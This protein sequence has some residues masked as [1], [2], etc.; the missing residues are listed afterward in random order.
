MSRGVLEPGA[1]DSTAVPEYRKPIGAGLPAPRSLAWNGFWTVAMSSSG[2]LVAV[3]VPPFL[4]RTLTHDEYGAWALALQFASYVLVLGFGLQNAVG[5]FVA[6]AHGPG[7]PAARS[8]VVV[9]A[10]HMACVAA[11]AGVVLVGAACFALPHFLT[12]M[13]EALVGDFRAALLLC[14]A[15]AALALIGMPFTGVFLGE[16]RAHVPAFIV[17]SGRVAQCALLVGAALGFGT[18]ESLAV[19]Y[20]I[21]Q[22]LITGGQ[23]VA[24]GAGGGV[25]LLRRRA[26]AAHYRELWS[27]C[28]PFVLWNSLAALSF[29][30]DLLI[31][32]KV[33]F[34][35]TPY[36]AVS[37]TIAT[38]FVGLLASAYNSL[39]PA[40]AR[41]VGTGNRR[42]LLGMLR[43]GGRMGVG[44]SLALGVPLVFAATAP[45]ALWVGPSYADA[46]APYLAL[47]IVAQIVR[48][49]MSMYGSV[50]IAAGR[51]RA[52]LLPPV[53]DAVVGL[54]VA[55]VL[56][57][58]IGATGVALGML[59]GAATSFA[60]WYWKD[61]LR[62]VFG[63]PHVA[64]M[65]VAACAPPVITAAAGCLLAGS[66]LLAFDA[67]GDDRARLA[68]SLAIGVAVAVVGL[69][70]PASLKKPVGVVRAS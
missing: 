15:A 58:Y 10:F 44:A 13:P 23:L 55:I 21:G 47:L 41:H 7:A 66:V 12:E 31:V 59:A 53:L 11:F 27:F 28:S 20:C 1:G 69:R 39:L 25:H 42:A 29:G 68:A 48:L 18:I 24:W 61:P 64:R 50:T 8:G 38:T 60:T 5:R 57:S 62:E 35:A 52:V 63:L 9:A 30:S 4:V 16:Q 36:Y 54:A 65:F 17:L 2:G 46:S 56:G 67:L 3:L 51:H 37:L 33:D 22:A 40:A 49:A 45:L 26:S 14:G 43:R 6:L 19:A 34:G 70:K 32:S